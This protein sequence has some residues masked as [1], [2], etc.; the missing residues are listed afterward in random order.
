M[1]DFLNHHNVKF[2]VFDIKEDKEAEKKLVDEYNSFT[3][4]TVVVGKDV[5]RGFD[6]ETLG[7]LLNL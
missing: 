6:L 7:K 5:V 1:K 2:E 3:T 4:P